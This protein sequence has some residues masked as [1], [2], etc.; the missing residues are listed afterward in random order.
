MIIRLFIAF[1]VIVAVIVGIMA[2]ALPRE[3]MIRL[4]MFRDF[5]DVSLP[6]LG[7]GALVKYLCS[8]SC[9]KCACGCGTQKECCN[10]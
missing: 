8:C 7:F 10:K 4:V 2:I 9:R 1:I 6:I 3:E 5:F